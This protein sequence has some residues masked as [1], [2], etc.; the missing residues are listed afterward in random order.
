M[1]SGADNQTQKKAGD[2]DSGAQAKKKP[3][4]MG[5]VMIAVVL[6]GASGGFVY[7]PKLVASMSGQEPAEEAESEGDHADEAHEDVTGKFLEL[8]NL[9]VNPAG[10]RGERFLMVSVAF[11]VPDEDALEHLHEREIQVRDVVSATLESLSLEDLTHPEARDN[12]KRELLEAVKPFSGTAAWVRVYL[13]R[14]VI[15]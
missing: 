3:L 4:L 2:E 7:A 6:G 11:E 12:L 10:S 1:A 8:E 15:Q 14:F 9:L 5:F 13:P